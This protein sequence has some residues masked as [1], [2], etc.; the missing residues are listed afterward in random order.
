MEFEKTLRERLY[1]KQLEQIER[2]FQY[3][4]HESLSRLEDLDIK[5]KVQNAYAIYMT[6]KMQ[7]M[8]EKQLYPL[9]DEFSKAVSEEALDKTKEEL[10]LEER[11]KAYIK[12][13]ELNQL[14]GRKESCKRSFSKKSFARKIKR[15]RYRTYFTSITKRK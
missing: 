15:R 2:D 10:E 1:Q 8:P 14:F 11:E 12:Y 7:G 9:F 5:S 6:N 13:Q 4:Y 3:R